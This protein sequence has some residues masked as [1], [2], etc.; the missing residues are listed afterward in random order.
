MGEPMKTHI[1][2]PN[3]HLKMGIGIWKEM[4]HE[5]F[6]FR[7]LIWRL[8]IRD[9]SAKYKQ[10]LLG[11]VWSLIMPFVAIGTFMYLG[12]AGILNIGPTG[13]PYPLYALI[14]LSIWQIFS[15]GLSAGSNSLVGAGDLITK[16]NFPREVIV[17]AS[18]AQ[19][20]YEFAIKM[21]LIILSFFIFHFIPSW[22]IIFLPFMLLPLLILT[23]GLSLILSLLNGV[24]RDIGNIVTLLLM[25]LM[26]LTPVLYPIKNADWLFEFNFLTAL[27]NAPRE[28]MTLGH[29][30]HPGHFMMA[31][32]VSLL[33][34]FISWR[35]FHLAETKIPERL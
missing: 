2:E 6:Q 25:F 9:I 23:V 15:T 28:M 1:Y 8:F 20:I 34:F 16:I 33:I 11:N 30:S 31:S 24:I 35:I 12:R 13:M 29:L 10:S 7:E 27:I 14:G 17:I 21:G 32:T 26:F 4:V 19:S 18:L 5:L 22:K 3:K